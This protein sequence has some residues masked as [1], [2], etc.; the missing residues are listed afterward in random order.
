MSVWFRTYPAD[1]LVRTRLVCLPNGGGAATFYRS[2]PAALPAGTEL[3]AVRYPGRQERLAEPPLES[4]AQ[5][6]DGVAEAVKPLLDRP[7]VIFGHSIGASIGHE[8]AIRMEEE[9]DHPPA[10]LVISSGRAP[11]L[12]RPPQHGEVTDEEI[13]AEIG[14]LGGAQAS[15]FA[16]PEFLELLM[17]MLRADFQ[18]RAGYT[19]SRKQVSCPVVS[20]VGDEDPGCSVAEAGSWSEIAA[21]EFDLKV[22]AGNHFYLIPR[23]AEVLADLS[24]RI[25]GL[26]WY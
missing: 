13:I 23:Q 19:P 25:A 3:L 12:G 5:I 24:Q 1:G 15:T 21:V 6:V 8:L 10:M 11:G 18:V 16:D 26:S 22:F 2:W 17:P 14:R 7:I 20:Y 9:F 4:V